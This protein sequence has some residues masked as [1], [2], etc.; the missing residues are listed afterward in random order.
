MNNSDCSKCQKHLPSKKKKAYR[1]QCTTEVPKNT[2]SHSD[3]RNMNFHTFIFLHAPSRRLLISCLARPL[4]FSPSTVIPLLPP[5]RSSPAAR[6]VQLRLVAPRRPLCI[7]PNASC[8]TSL[9]ELTGCRP[10]LVGVQPI[11]INVEIFLLTIYCLIKSLILLS[12]KKMLIILSAI[13][14]VDS[15]IE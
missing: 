14:I 2:T 8:H 3:L 4:L 5:H 6:L 7:V 15:T 12:I 10:V 1:R 13:K 11:F 9:P